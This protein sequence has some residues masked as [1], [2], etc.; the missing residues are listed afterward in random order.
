[1]LHPYKFALPLSWFGYKYAI[2]VVVAS[3]TSEYENCEESA[4]EMAEISL[5]PPCT[6]GNNFVQRRLKLKLFSNEKCSKKVHLQ[7]YL[8]RNFAF[9][10]ENQKV[11][12]VTYQ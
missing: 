4:L 6:T 3:S 1:M 12:Q 8:S 5:G 2:C 7:K 11:L 10:K 9:E